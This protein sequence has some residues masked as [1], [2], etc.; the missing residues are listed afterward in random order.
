MGSLVEFKNLPDRQTLFR[1]LIYSTVIPD[2]A[3][4]AISMNK[5]L[6][7]ELIDQKPNRRTTQLEKCFVRVLNTMPEQPV[8]KDIDV[9]F[10]PAY[11]VDVMKVLTSAYKQKPY[12]L[13]WPGRCF[14]GKL[15]YSEEGY[16]DYQ[17]YEIED[18]DIICVI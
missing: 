14:D 11:K 5:A 13:I 17:I 15:I 10:N 8:I 2:I 4:K 16:Q 9:M 3:S 7:S 18:Y 12:S 1:L 6:A